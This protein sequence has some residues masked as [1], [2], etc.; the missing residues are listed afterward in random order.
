MVETCCG[1]LVEVVLGD[2]SVPVILKGGSGCVAVLIGAEGPL[3]DGPT[4][5][6]LE[7]RWSQPGF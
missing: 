1:N 4:G 5:K 7:Q 2:E 3:I 6:I